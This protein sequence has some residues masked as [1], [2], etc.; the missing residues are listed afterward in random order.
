MTSHDAFSPLEKGS[1]T[2]VFGTAVHAVLRG[3]AAAGEDISA[4]IAHRL[5]AAHVP[6]FGA[7]V[8]PPSLEDVFLEVAGRP[9]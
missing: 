8:V 4:R 6:V 2:S 9:S 5:E 3:D 7:T 1:K